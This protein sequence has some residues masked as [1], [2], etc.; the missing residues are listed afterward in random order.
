MKEG[1]FG[2]CVFRETLDTFLNV[3]IKVLILNILNKGL[4]Y[5][6]VQPLE[7]VHQDFSQFW[8]MWKVGQHNANYNEVLRIAACLYTRHL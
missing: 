5:W 2:K 8:E 7:L 4:G 6:T 1:K 3:F